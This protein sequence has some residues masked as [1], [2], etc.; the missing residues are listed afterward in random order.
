[1]AAHT[2]P[3][4]PICGDGHMKPTVTA[5]IPVYNGKKYMWD[6]LQSVHWQTEP[7]DEIILVDDGSTDGLMEDIEGITGWQDIK[8]RITRVI[9][10][11][12]NLGIG[13]ARKT[14]CDAATRDYIAFC[15]ADDRWEPTFLEEMRKAA[16][17]YP[18][19]ILYSDYLMVDSKGKT[20]QKYT[21]MDFDHH[22]DFCI[23]AWKEARRNTMWV[24][25]SCVFIPRKVFEMVQFDNNLRIGEDLKFL[26]YA[27]RDHRFKRVPKMLLKYMVH[28]G[29]NTSTKINELLA[30]NAKTIQEAEKWWKKKYS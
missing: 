12:K 28:P 6:A 3:R 7:P 2:I 13:A 21:A 19:T 15:S 18:E 25:F 23:R 29:S 27:M 5:I 26:L 8:R 10:H 17:E 24:N 14:G 22:H 20:I 9:Q 16:K 1:M 30:A 11:K 4:L